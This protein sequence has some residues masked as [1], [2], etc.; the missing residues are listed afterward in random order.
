MLTVDRIGRMVDAARTE[1]ARFEQLLDHVLQNGR[2]LPLAARL[3]LAEHG[4]VEFAA[5][6][7]AA[8]RLVELTYRPGSL[9]A[10]LADRLALLLEGLDQSVEPDDPSYL[11]GV[12]RAASPGAI[13]VALA[14]LLALTE[15]LAVSNA[16]APSLARR[17]IRARDAALHALLA[18]RP[19]DPASPPG[20]VLV[21]TPVDTALL[22]WQA[23]TRPAL[24]AAIE[25]IGGVRALR[26]AAERARLWKNR[27]CA[28][29]L[30]LAG[31][32][33][34]PAGAQVE[35]GRKPRRPRAAA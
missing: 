10:E 21:G 17:T 2:V 13:G 9:T 18:A 23:G 26:R 5:M 25:P 33:G 35:Q 27:D 7:F 32:D 11:A 16:L 31:I 19:A 1:P 34:A 4:S 22:L 28:P 29:L 24:A 20:D 14:G 6:G 8:Q 30:A 15:Q 12:G 3:R